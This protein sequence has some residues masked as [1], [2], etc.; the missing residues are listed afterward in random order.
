MLD[1]QHP[2]TVYRREETRLLS[3]FSSSLI[4]KCSHSVVTQHWYSTAAASKLL[5]FGRCIEFVI[6]K[7]GHYFAFPQAK[8]PK[9]PSIVLV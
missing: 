3:L 9:P 1:K 8:C 2:V 6:F 4:A 5:F 7:L